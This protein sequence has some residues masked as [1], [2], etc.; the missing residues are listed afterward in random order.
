VAVAVLLDAMVVRTYL[1]PAVLQ[2]LGDRAWSMTGRR[3]PRPSVAT[4]PD[5]AEGTSAAGGRNPTP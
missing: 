1:V 2:L 5:G 4:A 3:G